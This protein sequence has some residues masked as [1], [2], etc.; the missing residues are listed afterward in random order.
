MVRKQPKAASKAK[1]RAK[2]NEK[3]LKRE[4]K[5]Q[6]RNEK[7]F[8]GALRKYEA[9]SLET[10]M[11]YITNALS[12]TPAF[13]APL[14]RLLRQGALN[15]LLRLNEPDSSG[16]KADGLERW[17]GR[18]RKLLD[19]PVM[20]QVKMLK[21][22]GIALTPSQQN[23]SSLVTTLFAVQFW[24]VP[25]TA[26]PQ[27]EQLRLVQT[28]ERFAKKRVEDIG[29]SFLD[30]LNLK[31]LAADMALWELSENKLTFTLC[32]GQVSELPVLPED[33]E[34]TLSDATSPACVAVAPNPVFNLP[35][36]SLFSAVSQLAP[37]QKWRYELDASV[38]V[39]C[40]QQHKGSPGLQ[41]SPS[42]SPVRSP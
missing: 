5:L 8:A 38:D 22:T 4:Q 40:E 36:R 23:D 24:V 18:A 10:E 19:L 27:H 26:L 1:A 21:A 32:P 6:E 41:L 35:C 28:M 37:E 7:L 42:A 33:G 16:G 3:T 34:W 30:G 13:V 12:E 29:R 9:S 11:A 14:A 17:Q 2:K 39:G 31:D 20:V 25:E 15:T